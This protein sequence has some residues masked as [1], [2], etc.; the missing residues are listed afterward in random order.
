[1][2]LPFIITVQAPRTIPNGPLVSQE[3]AVAEVL[4]AVQVR[5]AVSI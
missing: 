3:L 5:L 2:E 4:Q 1:M